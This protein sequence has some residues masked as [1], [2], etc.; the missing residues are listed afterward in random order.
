MLVNGCQGY[1]VGAG[2][3][4]A[5]RT[6]PADRGSVPADPGV[7]SPQTVT[8]ADN[9]STVR[10]APGGRLTI[11]LG[12]TY[13][14]FTGSSDASVV[15]SDGPPHFQS[16]RTDCVPGGGCGAVT[17]SFVAIGLGQAQI[18]AGR[19]VCG[20]AL[21]CSPDRQRFSVTVVVGD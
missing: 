8:D 13:W 7:E 12:S 1:Q 2:L 11:V 14:R 10:L 21:A 18:Y 16:M 15:A 20:E 19:S 5:A 17:Q 9:G 3:K 6:F 4:S